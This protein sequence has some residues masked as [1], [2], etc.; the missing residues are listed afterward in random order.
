MAPLRLQFIDR[1]GFSLTEWITA[2]IGEELVRRFPV[3]TVPSSEDPPPEP[4]S[5]VLRFRRSH[6]DGDVVVYREVIA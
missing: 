5:V 6:Q 1:K 2:P 3:E 4:L